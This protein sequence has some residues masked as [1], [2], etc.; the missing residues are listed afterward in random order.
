MCIKTP[1]L[2]GNQFVQVRILLS[3]TKIERRDNMRLKR[4]ISPNGKY[5]LIEHERNDHVE[6]GLPNTEN[7]FFV[8]KLKDKYARSALIGYL[9]AL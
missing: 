8:I 4:N 1:N 6:H 7:E 3:S 9:E 2:N 5:S